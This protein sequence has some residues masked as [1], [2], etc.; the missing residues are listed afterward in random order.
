LLGTLDSNSV[1]RIQRVICSYGPLPPIDSL[2]PDHLMA[3]LASDKK[4]LQGKVHF[5]LPSAIG[6]V[7]V[8]SGI[9][10]ALIRQATVET[11]RRNS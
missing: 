11:L 5:V 7:K 3:R 8:L 1:A 9:D 4:T 6:E 10:P 2:D